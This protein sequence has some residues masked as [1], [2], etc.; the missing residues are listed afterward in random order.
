[1]RSMFEQPFP[2]TDFLATFGGFLQHCG[3]TGM[4]APG[5]QDRHPLH[6][7]LPNA[8]YP[9][10]FLV[11]GQDEHGAYLGLGGA[12]RHT[13]AF[14]YNYLARPLVK[15]Y[16]GSSLLHISM[17]ITNLKASPMPLMYLAHI[18]F[19]PVDY[20]RL[21]YSAVCDPRHMR[22]RRQAPAH[23]EVT[24]AYRDFIARLAARPEKHLLLEPG[25]AFD[26]EV[27]FLVD[28]L[29]GPDGWAHALQ[30]HPDGSADVVRHRPEQ[31]PCGIRWICR[32]PDQDALGME[33]GTAEVDGYTAEKE[34]GHLKE[35]GAGQVFHCEL[36]AGML[37][38]QEAAQEEA[39]AD[40]IA[41]RVGHA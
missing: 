35:L 10:A 17:T 16:A 25:L 8:P 20:G 31:L 23:V 36:Q 11:A 22:V 30:V 5:P 6:G 12:Y 39:L 29:P 19:R 38:P 32:T 7:E 41:G 15:L 13:E 40:R 27:V 14:R 9:S 28:Y 24:P 33:A 34:K 3:A 18:N 21:V 4:G 26:P 2:T 37:T 1:M